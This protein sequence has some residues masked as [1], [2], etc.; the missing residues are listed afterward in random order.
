MVVFEKAGKQNTEKTLEMA[1]L[2]PVVFLDTAG[3]ESPFAPGRLREVKATFE[4]VFAEAGVETSP[5][6]SLIGEENASF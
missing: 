3:L 1:P 2:G 4:S 5:A 6:P